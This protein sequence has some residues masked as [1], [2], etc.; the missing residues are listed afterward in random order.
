MIPQHGYMLFHNFHNSKGD[1]TGPEK[2]MYGHF[3]L[4]FNIALRRQGPVHRG[5]HLVQRDQA[6]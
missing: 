1:R 5:G 4:R 6:G 3:Y 2:V